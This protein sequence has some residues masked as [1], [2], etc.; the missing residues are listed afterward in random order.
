VTALDTTPAVSATTTDEQLDRFR[1]SLSVS[2]GVSTD[3]EVLVEHSVDRSSWRPEG[4]PVAVVWAT[5]TA[6]VVATVRFAAEHGLS[7]VPRG[8]GTGLSGGAGAGRGTVVL[9]LSRMNRI[10]SVDA[11]D[12]LAEVEPGVITADLDRAARA[13]GLRYAPDPASWTISTIG[14]NIATNAG[15]LRCA[16][17]GVTGDSVAALTVVLADGS[18]VHTGRQTIKGVVGYDLTRLFV[19]SEGTLGI[20]VGAT[21]R[22]SPIPAHTATASAAFESPALAAAA[23]LELAGAGIRPATLE[24]L[25]QATLTAIDQ[26]QGTTL[27]SSAGAL[28]LLQTDGYGAE[29][30]L[31]AA[32]DILA[33]TA[34]R[35]EVAADEAQAEHLLS[36]R[37]LALPSVQRLGP[38]LIGD[39]AVPRSRLA[40]AMAGISDIARTSGVQ[41]FTFAHAGDGNLHPLLVVDEEHLQ[42]VHQAEDRIFRLALDLGG[43]LSGEHGV[44]VLKR[45]WV[46]AEIDEPT[47]ALHRAVKDALDP[48]HVLN[49]GK[50]AVGVSTRSNTAETTSLPSRRNRA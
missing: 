15:G 25:D 10:L 21:L 32:V 27:A 20:I 13:V 44:G 6:D 50:G 47:S 48:S 4:L 30:E 35:I 39:V 16:K 23:V 2:A 14:G 38:V 5:R 37:R 42:A 1:S 31:R 33:R 19:G 17:Y 8:A 24:L 36:T 11:V 34:S 46:D 49:A 3:L 40:E 18:V 41:I 43:T 45:P 7:V 29:P 28:L 12:G 26:A 22:L 9:D